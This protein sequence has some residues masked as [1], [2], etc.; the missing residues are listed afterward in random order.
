MLR[1]KT[2]Q[3]YRSQNQEADNSN[4]SNGASNHRLLTERTA[5]SEFFPVRTNQKSSYSR[6]TGSQVARAD[7]SS[8]NETTFGKVIS[9]GSVGHESRVSGWRRSSPS[10]EG[11]IFGLQGQ[12]VFGVNSDNGAPAKEGSCKDVLNA[13]TIITNSNA[14]IPEQEPRHKANPNKGPTAANKKFNGLYSK[15]Y[16][17][18]AGE[19][20]ASNSN[21]STRSRVDN[22]FLH[23]PSVPYQLQASEAG[24][25]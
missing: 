9:F 14:R 19:T 23:R 18:E 13:D 12:R 10:L 1:N 6:V 11:L 16:Y 20:K 8:A 21:D 22:L 7:H 15:S 5:V 3:S 25:R 2:Y 4:R 24:A 17:S